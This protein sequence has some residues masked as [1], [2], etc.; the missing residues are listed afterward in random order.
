VERQAL[1]DCSEENVSVLRNIKRACLPSIDKYDAC[2]SK[3]K[4]NPLNCVDVLRELTTC[5][6]AAAKREGINIPQQQGL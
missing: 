6:D 4:S 3:N 2:L 1:S 5:V